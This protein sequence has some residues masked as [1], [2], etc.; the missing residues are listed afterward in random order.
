MQ[1]FIARSMRVG[2]N[3]TPPIGVSLLRGG[4]RVYSQSAAAHIADAVAEVIPG[5]ALLLPVVTAD[6]F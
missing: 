3:P 6:K 2:G 1:L 4:A 5:V